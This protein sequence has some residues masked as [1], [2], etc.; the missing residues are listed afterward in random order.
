MALIRDFFTLKLKNVGKELNHKS[1]G[2]EGVDFLIGDNQL[3]LQSID[4]DTIQRSIK[5][6]K[7]D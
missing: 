4:L 3:Y 6:S 1:N 2:R 5:I 7:Q